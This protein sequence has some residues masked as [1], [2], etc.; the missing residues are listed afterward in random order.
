M[1]EIDDLIAK[2]TRER[3]DLRQRIVDLRETITRLNGEIEGLEQARAAIAKAP[4]PASREKR[5][6]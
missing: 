2:K 1:R 4:K 5:N 3:D 6:V